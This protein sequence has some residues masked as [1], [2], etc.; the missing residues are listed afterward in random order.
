[1]VS[2]TGLDIVKISKVYFGGLHTTP[3]YSWTQG[4]SLFFC[5]RFTH[6]Y[7]S[8]QLFCLLFLLVPQKGASC[9]LGIYNW[10]DIF[11]GPFPWG[12]TLYSHAQWRLSRI[13][14]RRKI[15]YEK[16]LFMP[17][18]MP[19]GLF[20]PVSLHLVQVTVNWLAQFSCDFS[21]LSPWVHRHF[22]IIC[23][24]HFFIGSCG[25]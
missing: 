15:C 7:F 19:F 20:V 21:S 10:R 2:E 13:E 17:T 25:N 12:T 22:E 9:L 23:L 5:V 6:F 4:S 14:T 18:E 16:A 8:I 3:F 1:M 24:I 11:K